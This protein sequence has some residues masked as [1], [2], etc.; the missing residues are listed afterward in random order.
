MKNGLTA[1]QAIRKVKEIRGRTASHKKQLETLKEY[2]T[3]L[4][5]VKKK[6]ETRNMN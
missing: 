6:R 4:L 2:E 5:S 3:Y 1:Q